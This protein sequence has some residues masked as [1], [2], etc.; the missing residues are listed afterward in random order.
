MQ[1][2][3]AEYGAG[4]GCHRIRLWEGLGGEG[5]E[6]RSRLKEEMGNGAAGWFG[7]VAG[8]VGNLG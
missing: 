3:W 2:G 8:S 7:R 4:F 6:T 5:F 1:R